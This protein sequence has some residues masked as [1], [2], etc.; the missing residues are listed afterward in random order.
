L[1]EEIGRIGDKSNAPKVLLNLGLKEDL[2]MKYQRFVVCS[3]V[4][5]S[6]LCGGQAWGAAG[7]PLWE[8]TFNYLPNYDTTSPNAL[9]ASSSTLIVCG[10]AYKETVAPETGSYSRFSL[11]FIRA[12]D[13]VTGNL[14]WQGTPLTLANTEGAINVNYFGNIIVNGNIAMVQ[15]GAYSYTQNTEGPPWQTLHL[16]KTVLRAYNIDNGQLIWENIKDGNGIFMQGA[17]PVT[18]NNRV[19]IAGG[20]NPI[21]LAPSSGWVRA[22]Q[23]PGTA[24]QAPL[25]LLLDKNQ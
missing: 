9:A 21:G 4:V 17:N 19:F 10:G 24:L 14:K 3:F 16:S 18:T 1:P 11:G 8:Q 12:Y 5:V 15:G 13:V 20:D 2:S 22:Y 25:Y 7:D 6:L 23:I